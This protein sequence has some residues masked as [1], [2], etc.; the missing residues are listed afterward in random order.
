MPPR[1]CSSCAIVCLNALPSTPTRLA[2][3]TRTSV[4]HTS[5]KC[6]F[7]VMSVIG[8]TSMPGRVH[9]HDDL[10]DAL[11][12][13]A[14]GVGAADEV[15]VVGELAEARPDLLAVDHEVV[16]VAHRAGGERRQVGAGVGLGHADA[17]RRLARQDAREELG[18]LIRRAV[19]DQGRAHLAV[20]EP[21][22][23]DRGTGGDQL[24][25]DDQPVDGRL[26]AATELDRPGHADPA[27][28]GHLLREVLREP[29]DPRVVVA[30]V[31]LDRLGG[32]LAG[33]AREGRSAR[34]SSRSPSPSSVEGRGSHAFLWSMLPR[35]CY[36][37]DKL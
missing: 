12:R 30:A 15:A 23:R 4:K 31:A 5:Q 26:A 35:R 22:R 6:R 28:R 13:R 3:G 36:S 37:V 17:P 25:A 16:A 19:V 24:L 32:D 14:V 21:H 8:R 29:V 34:V 18:L 33:V 27:V 20:G 2:T 9:R 7:V 10:A 11:V 1:S